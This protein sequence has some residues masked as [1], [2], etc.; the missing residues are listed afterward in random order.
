MAK[1]SAATPFAQSLLDRMAIL[2]SGACAA[3]C[4]LTP[5]LLVLLPALGVS[6]LADERFHLLLLWLLLPVS[7]YALTLGC[8]R[9]RD[10]RV[11]G[12]GLLG[13]TILIA[14][15]L[16]GHDLLGDAGER[17]LT[18]AGAAMLAAG[19]IRNYRLCRSDACPT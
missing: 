7:A 15:A 14:A 6:I 9:H 1:T 5:L 12:L 4:L 19:H 13:L 17:T 8:R 3:H 11:L 10:R 16:V 18:L 2:F